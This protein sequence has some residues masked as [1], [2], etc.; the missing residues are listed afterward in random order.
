MQF[1]DLEKKE[2][3]R[4]VDSDLDASDQE[5]LDVIDIHLEQKVRTSQLS[6]Q[7]KEEAKKKEEVKEKD[8]NVK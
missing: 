5:S 7:I 1:G 8:P 6:N 4:K 3:S 2:E